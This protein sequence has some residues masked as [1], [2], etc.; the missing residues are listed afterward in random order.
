MKLKV[1]IIGLG[2]F[3]NFHLDQL[4]KMEEVEVVALCAGNQEKLLLAH[5]KVPNAK[6]FNHHK[7]MLESIELDAVYVCVTPARHEDI[8]VLI[9][10]KGIAMYIE[11]PIGLDLERVQYIEQV[12]LESKVIHSIGYQERYSDSVAMI[13]KWL[14]NETPLLIE[15]K[16]LDKMP[17]ALW[18]RKMA[19]SGGQVIEQATHIIDMMRYLFGEISVVASQGV[20]GCVVA[21]HYDV[22]DASNTLLQFKSGLLGSL[23]CACYLE[24]GASSE[25]GLVIQ[26]K[27][28][29]LE[30]SW[31]K[32]IRLT[33]QDKEVYYELSESSH[34]RASCRFIEAVIQK[35]QSLILSDYSDARKTL[36]LTI[37]I[38]EKMTI[39]E[40]GGN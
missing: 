7:E 22:T 33:S 11:K 8:E 25:I 10:E 21:E 9:A 40:V 36:E 1:G 20:K 17:S 34:Y 28:S 16:W 31:G 26:G 5:Q 15:G 29:K 35:D 2:W 37:D 27:S 18:W 12:I 4:L 14:M 19:T 23:Q 39:T 24:E 3:G 13:K 32:G 6:C 38:T 30:Y